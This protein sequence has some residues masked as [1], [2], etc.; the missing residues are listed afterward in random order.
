MCVCVWAVYGAVFGKQ[1]GRQ[2]EVFNS[3]EVPLAA[4]GS[5]DMAFLHARTESCTG[6]GFAGHPIE[7]G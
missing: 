3:F 4:D 6:R 7:R 1:D 5:M 2:V